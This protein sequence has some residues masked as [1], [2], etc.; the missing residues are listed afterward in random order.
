VDVEVSLSYAGLGLMLNAPF[1]VAEMERRMSNAKDFAEAIAP[2]GDPA[3][4]KHS[5]RYLASFHV[6][7]G[8]YGGP[9]RDRAWAA[10]ENDSPEAL[11]VEYG[12]RGAEPYHVMLKALVEGARD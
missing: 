4:D 3:T 2:V 1:M 11:Y 7:S 10:L 6:D 8:N 9:S 5:G 12:E